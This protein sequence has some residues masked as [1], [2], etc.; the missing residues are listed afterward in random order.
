MGKVTVGADP[1]VML[2]NTDEKRIVPA[3]GIV[4]GTKRKP[5]HYNKSLQK[6]FTIQEDNVMVEFNI[7]PART[8]DQFCEYIRTAL[9]TIGEYLKTLG[10]YQMR[11]TSQHKF[12]NEQLWHEKAMAFGCSPDF[13]AYKNGDEHK[14]IDPATLKDKV[15]AWRFAGAHV[16]LGVTCEIP[17]F[18]M[19]AFADYFIGMSGVGFDKQTKR[20]ELY[21]QPGRYR[22]T[23]YGFEYRSPSNYWLQDSQQM[24]EVGYAA[25][26]LGKYLTETPVSRIQTTYQKIPWGAVR[27][28]IVDQDTNLVGAIY[29]Y[30]NE[31]EIISIPSDDTLEDDYDPA[32]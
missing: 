13:D 10:P 7:P 23:A 26:R 17:A 2:Y 18:V 31:E 27:K 19:A 16:H 1:E 6:G 30:I 11:Y 20:R 28:A 4:G 21:G 24:Y 3:C 9:S 22:P 12:A 15:G 32:P 5:L 25:F 14:A 8:A 29:A